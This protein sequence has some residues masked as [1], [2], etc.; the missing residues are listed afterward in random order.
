VQQRKPTETRARRAVA[1]D[2]TCRICGKA[3]YFNYKGPF[4]DVCGRCTDGLVAKHARRG[5][6]RTVVVTARRRAQGR[7]ALLLLGFLAGFA[8]AVLLR[9]HLPF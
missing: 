6:Q 1:L 4:D 3:I 9:A 8:A 2:R 5:A 7:A